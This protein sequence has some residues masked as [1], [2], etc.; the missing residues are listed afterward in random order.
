M[1]RKIISYKGL[2]IP[3]RKV[4]KSYREGSTRWLVLFL[5]LLLMIGDVYAFDIP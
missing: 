3:I 1:R 2:G 4:K 5:S